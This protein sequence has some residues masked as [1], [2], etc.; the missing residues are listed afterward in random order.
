M[1]NFMFNFGMLGAIALLV[2]ATIG[3]MMGGR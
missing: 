3:F 2:I 1:A